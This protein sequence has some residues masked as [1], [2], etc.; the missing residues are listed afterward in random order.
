MVFFGVGVVVPSGR[1]HDFG[2]PVQPPR[3]IEF[4][5]LDDFAVQ[6]A[7]EPEVQS[8][9]ACVQKL[10]VMKSRLPP[11]LGLF[12]KDVVL[13]SNR[14]V[15]GTPQDA[16]RM[17]VL[18]GKVMIEVSVVAIESIHAVVPMNR[19]GNGVCH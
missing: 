3:E 15:F 5:G 6:F 18:G 17:R 16:V 8:V 14:F 13:F 10:M 2:V 9:F 19:H 1:Q 11:M 7:C 4:P 12:T